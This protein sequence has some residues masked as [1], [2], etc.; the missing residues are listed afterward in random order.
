M[1][2]MVNSK[3]HFEANMSLNRNME[4]CKPNIIFGRK[5]LHLEWAADR[6]SEEM[7]DS[8]S[9]SK[10]QWNIG[11]KAIERYREGQRENKRER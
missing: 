1:Q 3:S 4:L 5:T 8:G 10:L 7:K 6:R 11:A 9:I 2:T